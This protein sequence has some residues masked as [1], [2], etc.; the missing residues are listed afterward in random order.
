MTTAQTSQ[1]KRPVQRFWRPQIKIK[2]TAHPDY[3]IACVN[4]TQ[5]SRSVTASSHFDSFQHNN[6]KTFLLF[7]CL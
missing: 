1:D 5:Y 2:V 7:Y 3:Y 4:W 6:T